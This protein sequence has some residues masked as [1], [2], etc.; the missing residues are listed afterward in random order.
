MVIAQSK[1]NEIMS[2]MSDTA[3]VN[4]LQLQSELYEN[5][6]KEELNKDT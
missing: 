1:N 6:E 2:T 3:T 4:K 5:N